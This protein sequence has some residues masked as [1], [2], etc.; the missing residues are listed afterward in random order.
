MA[1]D[2]LRIVYDCGLK[3]PGCVLIQAAAGGDPYAVTELFPSESWLI[4][5]TPGMRVIAGTKEEWQKAAAITRAEM[6]RLEIEKREVGCREKTR[7]K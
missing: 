1:D 4:A 3:R 5:P 2:K 6:K 7:L